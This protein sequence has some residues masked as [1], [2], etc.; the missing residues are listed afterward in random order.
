MRMHF[1]KSITC[2][3]AASTLIG[4]VSLVSGC[5]TTRIPLTQLNIPI[6][7][8]SRLP[9]IPIFHRGE[10][11]LRNLE[12]TKAFDDMH[13]RIVREY[14][15][16]EWRSIDWNALY[17]EYYPEVLHAQEANDADAYYLALRKY[18]YSIPDGNMRISENKELRD[19][20]IGGGYG[21][22]IRQVDDGRVLACIV[23]EDGP[24][25]RAGMAWGA[26]ILTWNGKP[27]QEALNQTSILWADMP[28]AT[29]SGRKWLQ[30]RLLVR[31][32]EGTPAEI[33]FKNEGS[34]DTIDAVLTARD[35]RF[36]TFQTVRLDPEELSALESPIQYHILPGNFGYLRVFYEGPS[37]NAP[38]PAR[39][40]K[41]AI[42]S[43]DERNV[44][45]MILDVRGN[46]GGDRELLTKFLGHF[47]AEP[48]L[49][50]DT[51]FYDAE[52]QTFAVD[53]AAR[54]TIEPAEPLFTKPVI[55]LVTSGTFNAG[56]GFALALKDQ[57]NVQIVGFN[58]THGSFGAIGGDISMPEGITLSYPV[59]RTIDANGTVLVD[60]N[61]QGEGGITP[62]NRP[63]L[64]RDTLYNRFVSDVD[65][66]LDEAIS[67]LYDTAVD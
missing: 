39:V 57:P 25:A 53:P 32:P 45:G 54:L 36:R 2:L 8:I 33:S 29:N 23:Q 13:L 42:S 11:D 59:G 22:A 63:P 67:I 5:T 46:T 40:F 37:W 50:S 49:F 28:P 65:I 9:I 51:A 44:S 30:A 62:T 12:W 41:K 19:A 48:V 18:I 35:D 24:A 14:P 16:T 27:I 43:F 21:L 1:R 55:V 20:A 52:S 38:F 58:G 3:L 61:G 64:T 17:A 34:E 47:F 60:S 15:F 56:E 10:D 31:A 66:L 26:E 7:D 6:P 4:T